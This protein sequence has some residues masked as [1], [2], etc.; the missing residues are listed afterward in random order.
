MELWA[1]P[2]KTSTSELP[3]DVQNSQI[4]GVGFNFV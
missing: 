2:T 4:Y 3:L 1:I